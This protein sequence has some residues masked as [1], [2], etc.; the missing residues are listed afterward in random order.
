[1][2]TFFCAVTRHS[3]LKA[4]TTGTSIQRCILTMML[5]FNENNEEMSRKVKTAA[6]GKGCLK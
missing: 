5:W 6:G 3:A 1:M 2:K 4:A